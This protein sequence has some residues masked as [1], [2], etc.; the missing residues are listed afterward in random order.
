L[1]GEAMTEERAKA[2]IDS[3]VKAQGVK[4]GLVMKS[5]R[6]GLTGSLQG[7]DLMQSWLLLSQ[8]GWDRG[9]L[10]QAIAAIG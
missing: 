4:K 1:S 8:K 5:L 9:R 3:V 7:P 2:L 10:E 6:A